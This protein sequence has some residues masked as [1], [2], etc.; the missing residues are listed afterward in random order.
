MFFDKTNFYVITGGPGSGK[1]TLLDALEK[2]GFLIVPEVAREIIKTQMETGG[3]AL[4][5]GNT[6]LYTELMLK[7]SVD[8]FMAHINN[9]NTTFFDRG[10]LDTICYAEM[11]GIG[12]SAAMNEYA[13]NYLYN[14]QVFILPPWLEIYETDSERKQN[15]EEAKMTY[16]QMKATYEKYGYKVVDVPKEDVKVRK[17]FIISKISG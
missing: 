6:G 5:W 14:R 16:Q 13:N 15:W 8:S 17:D 1:T 11:I 4:P 9:N 7:G 10:I 3:N 2:D 12:I